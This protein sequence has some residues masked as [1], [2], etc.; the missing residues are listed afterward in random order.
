MFGPIHALTLNEDKQAIADQVITTLGNRL[1]LGLTV[2]PAS[3]PG[4]VVLWASH[5]SPSLF[6][7]A[8]NSGVVSRLS[9]PGS[10]PAGRDHRPPQGDRQPRH[11]LDP[12]R[13]GREALHRPGGQHRRGC[14]EQ[15][16]S[17]FGDMQEQPLSAALLVADVASPGFDGSCDNTAD[18]F[19]PPPCDVTTFSTGLRNMY[20]FVF[21]SN[22]EIYGPDN[23]L[24][25]TGTFPPSPSAPGSSW[26]FRAP[27]LGRR[28]SRPQSWPATRP[29]RPAS[30]GRATT[31]TLITHQRESSVV[32]RNGHSRERE[33][34]IPT[35]A[36]SHGGDGEGGRCPSRRA[37]CRAR[38]SSRCCGRRSR[39]CCG[40]RVA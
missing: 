6:E 26:A 17:E 11:Q 36:M 37:R 30:A 22:G 1:T 13:A 2:D 38:R 35:D 24:G 19:G 32:G 4:N 25:V 23:G 21:H 14:A 20:D 39:T 40:G 18:I 12:L 3:T 8:P 28:S 15:T 33:S 31:G 9:G 5:S 7:G 16:V 34:E 10:R 29:P 27:T